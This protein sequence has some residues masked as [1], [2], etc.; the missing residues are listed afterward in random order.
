L[1]AAVDISAG[2]Q[3]TEQKVSI[4]RPADGLSPMY[5]DT[6]LGSETVEDIQEDNPIDAGSVNIDI[7]R[8]K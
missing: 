7:K 4:K 5:Y 1:H 2:T 3:L 8:N 6:V